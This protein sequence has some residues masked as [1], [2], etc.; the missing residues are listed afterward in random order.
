MLRLAYSFRKQAAKAQ[1]EF[2]KLLKTN[3][4]TEPQELDLKMEHDHDYFTSYEEF[5]FNPDLSKTEIEEK[6]YTCTKCSKQFSKEKKYLKHLLSHEDLLLECDI[7]QKTYPNQAL[8]DKHKAKHE[9]NMCF[10]SEQSF[11]NDMYLLEDNMVDHTEEV[12]IKSEDVTPALQLQCTYCSLTFEKQR[13]LSMH[14]RKH[15]N[16]NE[17]KEFICDTCGKKFHMK[18]LLMRHVA[19]HS[20][21]KPYKCEKCSKTYARRDRLMSHMYTHKEHKRY[22]CEY[23]KK[24]KLFD[25]FYKVPWGQLSGRH[26]ASAYLISSTKLLGNSIL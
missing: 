11:T 15:R 20:E 13:S 18:H 10:V 26:N 4:K 7:C 23:C 1:T 19:M 8:L 25:L 16:K 21:V 6:E 14:M 9:I 3:V 2:K 12:E 5:S 17:K 22:I 24:S